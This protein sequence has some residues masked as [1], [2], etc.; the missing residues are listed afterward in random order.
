M[1]RASD[2]KV[3]EFEHD[4]ELKPSAQAKHIAFR[5]QVNT[6]RIH[7]NATPGPDT[8]DK[9]IHRRRER[10]DSL[11]WV[12]DNDELVSIQREKAEVIAQIEKLH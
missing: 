5:S 10:E 2:L 3:E 9:V 6:I 8:P 7:E 1:P 4:P 12:L 11:P